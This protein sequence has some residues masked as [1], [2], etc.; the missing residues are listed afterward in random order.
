MGLVFSLF[1]VITSTVLGKLLSDIILMEV[2][3][4]LLVRIKLCKL[5]VSCW[6]GMLNG[7]VLLHPFE[8]EFPLPC[9][10]FV[11]DGLLLL[12]CE[13]VVDPFI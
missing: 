4:V 13:E 12:L 7:L 5:E 8:L 9:C 2:L 1:V 11:G 3:K 10:M 6:S